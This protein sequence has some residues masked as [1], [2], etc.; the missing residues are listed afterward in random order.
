MTLSNPR[1]HKVSE[2]ESN[3]TLY[4]IAGLIGTT[5]IALFS[6]IY[7]G[8]AARIDRIEDNG[9][10]KSREEIS[11]LKTDLSYIKENLNDIKFSQQRM[12]ELLE[13]AQ[14]NANKENAIRR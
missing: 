1:S 6:I 8:L 9:T 7:G 5:L 12:L 14:I 3:K 4:W 11:K 2:N 13:R 10:P